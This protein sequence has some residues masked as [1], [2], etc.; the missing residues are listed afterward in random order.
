MIYLKVVIDY[1]GVSL[2]KF[3]FI[4]LKIQFGV[5]LYVGR[6]FIIFQFFSRIFILLFLLKLV[7]YYYLKF[8]LRLLKV[9][10]IDAQLF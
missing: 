6:D 8:F 2:R 9:I 4:L 7:L 5:S 3:G 10:I 1:L